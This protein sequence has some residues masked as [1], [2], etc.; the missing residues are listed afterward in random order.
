MNTGH[1]VNC[2]CYIAT[3]YIIIWFQSISKGKKMMTKMSILIS[4]CFIQVEDYFLRTIYNVYHGSYKIRIRRVITVVHW[5]L[6]SRIIVRAFHVIGFQEI[7]FTWNE[8][9][10]IAIQGCVLLKES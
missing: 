1:L 6:G 10:L 9:S 2:R 5:E 3:Q 4:K 7:S 8:V